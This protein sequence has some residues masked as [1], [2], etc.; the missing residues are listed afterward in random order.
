V[1]RSAVSVG[2]SSVTVGRPG[3][4]DLVLLKQPTSPKRRL[5]LPL[6]IGLDDAR[7]F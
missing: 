1:N 7:E 3:S 2:R 5:D 6:S 4:I